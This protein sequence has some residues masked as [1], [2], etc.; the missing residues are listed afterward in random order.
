MNPKFK[1]QPYDKHKYYGHY[2]A[3]YSS[4]YVGI[5]VNKQC[6]END[7]PYFI[8]GHYNMFKTKFE[9]ANCIFDGIVYHLRLFKGQDISFDR[10][11]DLGNNH[12]YFLSNILSDPDKRG[13]YRKKLLNDRKNGF[14]N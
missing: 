8:N 14:N 2:I 10:I 12:K 4:N 3:V 5:Y 9:A 6:F 1:T 13:Q 11:Y 7:W